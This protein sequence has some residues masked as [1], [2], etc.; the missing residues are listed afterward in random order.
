MFMVSKTKTTEEFIKESKLKH[1]DRFD[2]SRVIYI[3]NKSK[4][5]IGCKKHGF[6]EQRASSHLSGNGCHQCLK[7]NRNPYRGKEKIFEQNFKELGRKIHNGKY[8][9]SMSNYERNNKKMSIICPH[10]GIFFQ[11]AYEH[12]VRKHGCPKCVGKFK[13]NDEFIKSCRQIHNNKYDYRFCEYKNYN[14]VIRIICPKHG[15]FSQKARYHIS[16]SGCFSCR[17]SSGEKIIKEILEKNK[18]KYIQQKRFGDCIY[19]Y[20][21]AFDFYLP[22]QNICIEYNG[23]Q[24]YEPIKYFGGIEEFDKRIERDKIKIEYC[25]KNNIRL[26]VIKYN[27]DI[28]KYLTNHI[29]IIYT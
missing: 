12:T 25:Q 2:Y 5:S 18:I 17:E 26:I 24:H 3:N 15:E 8:D 1:G 10:H 19:K 21:L 7:E 6:F 27:E 28:I 11:T 20:K 9:Y 4:I 13:T 22:E 14:S 23:I 29:K 16:G